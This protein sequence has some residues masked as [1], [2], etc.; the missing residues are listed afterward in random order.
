[1][2]CDT[3]GWQLKLVAFCTLCFVV[4]LPS[5]RSHRLCEQPCKTAR[6]SIELVL[7]PSNMLCDTAGW[8]LKLV[9]LCTLCFVVT[10]PSLRSHC[11][12]EQPCKIARCSIE[13]VLQPSY[14]LC[15]TAGWQLKLVALCTLCFVV[16]LPSL[17]SHC[18]CEQPCKIARCSIELVLQPSYMLCDT[19]GWQLKLVALCTLC[20][21]VTLPSL[22]SHCLC[23]QP[24]KTARCLIELVLQPSNMLCDTAGWQ[25]M[26]VALCTL[27]FVVSLPSLRS[28]CLCEQPCKTARYLIELV[29]QLSNMLCEKQQDV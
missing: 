4:T 12:C 10:L 19:A 29:L 6:C 11:L 27:C 14:M 13:L 28:H 7:Q 25:L 15:D 22:R 16:T 26:L 23:A 9:A 17:R 21:V 8:Q 1:M 3:A 5:L 24:C 20:F 18:L 2:L